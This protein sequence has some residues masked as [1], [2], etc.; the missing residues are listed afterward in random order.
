MKKKYLLYILVLALFSA[1]EPKID[2]FSPSEG[3]ADFTTYLAMGNSLTAGYAD[4][5]LYIS[6]QTYSYPNILAGQFELAGGGAFTQPMMPTEAGVGVGDL[7]LRSKLVLGMATDCLGTV[8]LGP[9]PFDPAPD[10]LEYLGYLVTSV[11]ADGPYNNIGVPGIKSF[12]VLAPGL[13]LLNPY[14]G[15]FAANPATDMLIGEAAKVNPTF[16]TLWLGNNDVLTY[17]L[18]GGVI[19][20]ITPEPIFSGSM[21]AIVGAL[22]ANGASGAIANVP[23]IT[24]IPFFTTVPYC[25]LVLT[26][27]ADVAAL[28]YGYAP[29]NFII[30]Q[31]GGDTLA[32]TL[33]A[34][35]FVIADASL[36]W[37]VRQIKAG[38]LILLSIPQDSL[39]CAGW[40]SMVPIPEQYVLKADQI[41]A[42]E[43]A[44]EAYN[45]K[46]AELAGTFSL[47]LVDMNSYLKEFETG[48]IFDGATYSTQFILGGL[49]SLDGIHLNPR[50]NAVITNHFIDAINAK[51]NANL[52]QVIIQDYPGIQFP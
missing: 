39:K 25:G 26:D 50:G 33:G 27:E 20:S 24:T 14:F 18:A 19:D 22:T 40:G 7:G 9:V 5:A 17:A 11:A 16:F 3:N 38:E 30:N 4:G 52:P 44:T 21:D 28:N 1:C 48:M 10:Q 49:F 42:I 36:P 23:D 34:N 29:L 15:R 32:F 13:G 31:N 41:V 51:Y 37:G 8:S 45:D 35:P 46:I 6:G 2:E 12:H 43:T 47:A